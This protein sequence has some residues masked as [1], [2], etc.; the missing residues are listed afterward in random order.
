MYLKQHIFFLAS[1]L[2]QI[3]PDIAEV[4][5]IYLLYTFT[6]ANILALK[7]EY[8]PYVAAS[9]DIDTHIA[10]ESFG[11]DILQYYP[12]GQEQPVKLCY[13]SHLQQVQNGL[14]LYYRTVLE[15]SNIICWKITYLH[16]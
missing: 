8:P 15:I 4:E 14:F 6:S 11:R 10:H 1:K 5:K 2:Q 3:N 7:D 9:K 16:H 13:Y 12:T